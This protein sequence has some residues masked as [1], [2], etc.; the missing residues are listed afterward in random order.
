M[1]AC[2]GE[3]VWV[4][5]CAGVRMYGGLCACVCMFR[6]GRCVNGYMCMRECM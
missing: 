6:E 3:D 5:V 4:R 2:V 1:S